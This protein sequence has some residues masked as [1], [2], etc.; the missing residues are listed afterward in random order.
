MLCL[1]CNNIMSGHEFMTG[2][3]GFLMFS[4]LY[5]H[6]RLCVVEFEVW[7]LCF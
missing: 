6:D 5:D 2:Y 7:M 1:Y 3:L 4:L